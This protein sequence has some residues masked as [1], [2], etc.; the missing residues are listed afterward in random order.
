M[1]Q[2]ELLKKLTEVFQEFNESLNLPQDSGNLSTDQLR[3]YGV[4]PSNHEEITENTLVNFDE[5]LNGISIPGFVPKEQ[6]DAIQLSKD[7]TPVLQ[8]LE[9]EV[10]RMSQAK[11]IL[12]GEVWKKMRLLYDHLKVHAKHQPE[13]EAKFS[14][15][16]DSFKRGKVKKEEPQEVTNENN[17][18][19]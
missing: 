18:S 16:F 9:L 15:L 13:V 5:K 7:I 10:R 12:D 1:S 4:V 19:E 17:S 6:L 11:R 2:V 8:K 3:A 14:E